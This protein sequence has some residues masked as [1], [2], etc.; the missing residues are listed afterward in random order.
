MRCKYVRQGGGGERSNE[1]FAQAS[2]S[3]GRLPVEHGLS[4]PP[5]VTAPLGSTAVL[6]RQSFVV[7]QVP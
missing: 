1:T 2:A 4:E 5:K 6:E 3:T 7:V